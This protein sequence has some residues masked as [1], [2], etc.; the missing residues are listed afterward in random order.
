MKNMV[1]KPIH[2]GADVGSTVVI[3]TCDSVRKPAISAVIAED[4]AMPVTISLS[5]LFLCGGMFPPPHF[6]FHMK[7][8]NNKVYKCFGYHRKTE[9]MYFNIKPENKPCHYS[10]T[11]YTK[12]FPVR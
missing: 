5:P 12:L 10:K 1:A 3:G 11:S 7:L 9:Y 6:E 2:I 4:A 8:L